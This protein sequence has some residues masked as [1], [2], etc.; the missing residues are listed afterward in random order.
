M[1]KVARKE[2]DI[3]VGKIR[4][5]RPSVIVNDRPI[6]TEGDLI[7]PHTPYGPHTSSVIVGYWP[8]VWAESR[9]VA[10]KTDATSCGHPISTGS[11]NVFVG[12]DGN[13]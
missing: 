7:T 2:K 9:H 6:A 3:A 8:N 4:T 10:R 12:T 1:A 13:G 11:S 5:G